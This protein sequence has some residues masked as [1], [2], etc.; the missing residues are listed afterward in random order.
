MNEPEHAAEAKRWLSYA[1]QDLRAAD[2]V[3]RQQQGPPRHVCWLA[4]QAAEKAIKA[5]LVFLQIEFPKTHDLDALR[6]RLPQD[7]A[8]RQALLDLAELTEWAVEARYPGDWPEAATDDARVA[9][10]QARRVME[11]VTADLARRG[12]AIP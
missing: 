10:E 9:L 11:T 8:V 5:A 7:W 4:Q 3:F 2:T 1:A 6:N 12:V